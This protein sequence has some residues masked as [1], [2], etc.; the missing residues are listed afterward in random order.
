MTQHRSIYGLLTELKDITRPNL[1]LVS[2]ANVPTGTVPDPLLATKIDIPSVTMGDITIKRMGKQ[3]SIPGN[4]VD[5]PDVTATFYDDVDGLHRDFFYR[6][7]QMAFPKPAG[8]S[9]TIFGGESELNYLTSKVLIQQLNGNMLDIGNTTLYKAWPK[10]I[11]QIS[12]DYS[13]E[14]ALNTFDVTFAY[15]YAENQSKVV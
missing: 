9:D 13:S 8:T 4:S 1:F 7:Q 10:V 14:D 3:I 11:G 5:W 15:S 12:M 6:W 2:I